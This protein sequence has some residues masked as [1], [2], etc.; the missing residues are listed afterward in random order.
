[1]KLC[2][3][4]YEGCLLQGA[5]LWLSTWAWWAEVP[6]WGASGQ[7]AAPTLAVLPH[8]PTTGGLLNEP[9]QGQKAGHVVMGGP[10]TFGLP[11]RQRPGERAKQR[12]PCVL[13]CRRRLR[14]AAVAWAAVQ[15]GHMPAA[16]LEA[17]APSFLPLIA[18]L[19]E[20]QAPFCGPRWQKCAWR[21]WWSLRPA[22]R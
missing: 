19:L 14:D 22:A 2:R 20:M 7:R 8:T 10:D 16:W 18:A 4:Q 6:A 21:P 5:G 1:M 12:E 17:R 15:E 9:R 13:E 3:G 11:P